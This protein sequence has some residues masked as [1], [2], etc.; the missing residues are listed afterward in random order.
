VTTWL[1]PPESAR[2]PL[3]HPLR[4]AGRA[5]AAA[6]GLLVAGALPG[7]S[8]AAESTP[9]AP[10]HVAVVRDARDAALGSAALDP[11]LG[12][13]RDQTRRVQARADGRYRLQLA[14]GRSLALT[15][16]GRIAR[17]GVLGVL[18]QQHTPGLVF[19]QQLGPRMSARAG[20]EWT[21]RIADPDLSLHSA[22]DRFF[23]E[24]QGRM[25]I[26]GTA[27]VRYEFLRSDSVGDTGVAGDLHRFSLSDDFLVGRLSP[28]LN[29]RLL[30]QLQA[31]IAETDR[32]QPFYDF[33]RV[34]F[35]AVLDAPSGP[36][37]S[38]H[39]A[40]DWLH[41]YEGPDS[42]PGDR[43]DYVTR[44]AARLRI[45]FLDRFALFTDLS[46]RQDVSTVAV[47]DSQTLRAG[48]GLELRF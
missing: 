29:L 14:P 7:A 39:V 4:R 28:N 43:S 25:P 41:Y 3:R 2:P 48:A 47:T 31:G 35:G 23:T 16:R 30:P 21:A 6:L 45:P 36:S 24:F 11:F 44:L 26:F 8:L 38:A 46:W 15:Y 5:A 13:L 1:P 34:G 33:Q 18:D 22:N 12:E 9:P 17:D 37:L 20:F 10:L 42:Q 40:F 32:G 19:S 27:N